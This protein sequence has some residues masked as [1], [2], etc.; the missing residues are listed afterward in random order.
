MPRPDAQ[1]LAKLLVEI[2]RRA[3]LE[4]G[5]PYKAKAYLRAAESLRHLAR[6]LEELIK[7]GQ[8]QEIAGVGAAIARRIVTLGRQG[9][10]PWLEKLRAKYPATLFELFQGLGRP[11]S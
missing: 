4:G 3:L 5:N 6:P 11:P 1:E 2:G 8:L 10:D 7:A 9:R